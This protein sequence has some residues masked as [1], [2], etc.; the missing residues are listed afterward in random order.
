MGILAQRTQSVRDVVAQI[1]QDNLMEYRRR[2]MFVHRG[3]NS[4]WKNPKY[5][6]IEIIEAMGTDA[7]AMFQNHG[8]EQIA[9]A[10]LAAQNGLAYT[11]LTIPEEHTL[12]PN[13]DGSI[14]VV[15]AEGEDA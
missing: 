10:T 13:E 11:P 1:K 8:Q 9:L 5:T 4:V 14:T 6:P 2:I 15:K 7:V 12:T 3:F